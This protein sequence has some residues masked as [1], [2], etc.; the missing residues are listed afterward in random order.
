MVQYDQPH[1]YV[2]PTDY[3]WM[4]PEHHDEVSTVSKVNLPV[5]S[6]GKIKLVVLATSTRAPKSI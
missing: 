5:S 6:T 3:N 1:S 2:F 4:K